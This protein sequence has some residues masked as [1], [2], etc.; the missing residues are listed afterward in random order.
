MSRGVGNSERGCPCGFD[1]A[2]TDPKLLSLGVF[3]LEWWPPDVMKKDRK[4]AAAV[5]RACR[6]C[7]QLY[8]LTHKEDENLPDHGAGDASI[9][10]APKTIC[11]MRPGLNPEGTPCTFEMGHRGECSWDLTR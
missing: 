9:Q 10:W 5:V 4:G 8:A 6:C 7:R 3:L 1:H 2:K 11:G